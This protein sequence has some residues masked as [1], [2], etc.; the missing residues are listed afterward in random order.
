MLY[1]ELRGAQH[2]FEIFGSARAVAC[3]EA[4][5]RFLHWAHDRHLGTVPSAPHAP[6]PADLAAEDDSPAAA[7]AAAASLSVEN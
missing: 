2:A 1:A 6:V 5:E 3:I 7:P 4:A